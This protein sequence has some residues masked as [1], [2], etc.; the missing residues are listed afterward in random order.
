M[1][2]FFVCRLFGFMGFSFFFFFVPVVVVVL[3]IILLLLGERLNTGSRFP[4]ESL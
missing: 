1:V 3:K 2:G 4:R